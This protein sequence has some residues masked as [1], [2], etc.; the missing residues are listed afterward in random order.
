MSDIHNKLEEYIIENLKSI[1]P[2]TR[3]TPGSGCG[4]TNGDVSNK[5]FFVESKIKH[6]KE[7]IIIDYK[8]EWLTLTT[9]MPLQSKKIP[10]IVTEN[11]YGDKFCTMDLDDF[12][13][14]AR[15][16]FHG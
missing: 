6:T 13:E 3:K 1:D 16:A 5:Y 2:L 7:N 4:H 10:I 12:F 9:R 15:K 8:N 11:K 14:L